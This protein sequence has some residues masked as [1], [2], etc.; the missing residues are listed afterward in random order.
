MKE[1]EIVEALRRESEEFRRIEEEHRALDE[2][3]AEMDKNR[4]LTTEE[5]ME[6]KKL[7]KKKLAMKDQ[8]AE[9]IRNY[10]SAHAAG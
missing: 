2:R 9:L 6:R 7:Q 4:Y 5:E 10:R 3:I 1:Q 8:M